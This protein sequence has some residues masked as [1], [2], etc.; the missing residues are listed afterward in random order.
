MN[1]QRQPLSARVKGFTL[2]ELAVT[3]AVL[4]ILCAIAIP[5]FTGLIRGNRLSGAANELVVAFQMARSEAIKLNGS[6]KMCRSDN[7]TS[8][9]AGNTWNTLLVV[10]RGGAVLRSVA[11]RP[12]LQIQG[13]SA[14]DAMSDVITF[15]ADGIA[16]TSA[17]VPV[18]ATIGVCMPVSNPSDNLRQV[19]ITGG[20]RISVN[21]ASGGGACPDS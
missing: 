4:A 6:V 17:G 8:C 19:V 3:V 18:A 16:R 20:S 11:L 15:S 10:D 2:V 21:R 9:A 12:G 7:G 14:L 13:D 1:R 5:S